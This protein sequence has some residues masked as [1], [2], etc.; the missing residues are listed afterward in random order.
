LPVLPDIPDRDHEPPMI[1]D[2]QHAANSAIEASDVPEYDSI[3]CSDYP[4]GRQ[5]HDEQL[6]AETS[7]RLKLFE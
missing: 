7:Q 3:D 2:L 1:S 4:Y 6:H 5:A